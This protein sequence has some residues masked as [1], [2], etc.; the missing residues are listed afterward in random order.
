MDRAKGKA[1]N[2]LP[3]AVWLQQNACS[4]FSQIQFLNVYFAECLLLPDK[5]CNVVVELL[6]ALEQRVAGPPPWKIIPL[7]FAV[8]R[9]L[10]AHWWTGSFS[11]NEI[12]EISLLLPEN[13]DP[14]R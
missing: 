14:V 2:R 13:P 4:I 3:C 10:Q 9:L 1:L 5:L 7:N 6:F 8:Q 11:L 12:A